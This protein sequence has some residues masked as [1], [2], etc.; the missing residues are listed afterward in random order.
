V[1][2]QPSSDSEDD[3]REREAGF[4]VSK[5]QVVLREAKVKQRLRYIWLI[6]SLIVTFGL[7]GATAYGFWITNRTPFSYVGLIAGAMST[8]AAAW[9]ILRNRPD[10][11]EEAYKVSER[12]HEH[13]QLV[14]AI[15]REAKKSLRVYRALSSRDIDGYRR[16]ATRN[17]RVHNLF[18]GI[19]IVGSIVVTSLTSAGLTEPALRWGGASLAALVSVSAGFTGYFKFRERGF[20]Q[21]QTADAIEKEY[22]AVDLRVGDYNIPNE[23]DALKIYAQKVE[24]LKEE[25]RKREL[26]LE[27]SSSPEEK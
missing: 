7:G 15:E 27:Q 11:A 20:N 10:I 9:L 25:Q 5:Q 16:K 22:N 4:K 3:I 1:T 17:R 23:D 18:Q 13:M 19:I 8:T 2:E 21:Q 12:E 24:A 6:G 14:A 26:Q